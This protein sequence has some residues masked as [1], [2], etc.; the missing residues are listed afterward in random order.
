ML[1]TCVHDNEWKKFQ[2]EKFVDDANSIIL[3]IS[4]SVG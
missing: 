1:F 2:G 3:Y 4:C